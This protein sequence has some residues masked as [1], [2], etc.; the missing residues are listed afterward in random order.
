MWS[1]SSGYYDVC[2]LA[3]C[4]LMGVSVE[5]IEQTQGEAVSEATQAGQEVSAIDVGLSRDL[6]LFD[7]TMIGVG[8]MIGAGIFVLTGIAAGVA[9]P[10]LVLAFA[11]NGIVTS[12]T[13]MSYAELGSAFPQAGGGYVWV[14]E[15]LGGLQGFL[16]GWMSWFAAAVAGSLY[17]LAF[18][19]F[20]VEL[21]SMAGLPV[22]QH[23]VLGV[24]GHEIMR[25]LF[26]TF[27]VITFTFINFMGAS[28]TGSVGNAITLAKV[29]I[30]GLFTAFGVV[31][32]LHQ[33]A[34]HQRFSEGFMPNGI[35]GVFMAMGLTFIAFEGYEIIAQSGEEVIDPKRNVPRA[36]FWAI[37]ISV[38]IYVLVAFTTIGAIQVPAE[39]GN[40]PAYQYLGLEKETAIVRAAEQF[41]PFGVGGVFLL[42]SGLASTMSALNAVTYSSSRVSFAMGRDRNL[43]SFFGKIHDRR[44]TPFLAVII[45]GTLIAI[46]AWSLPIEALAAA[47]DIMFLLLFFQVNVSTMI[48]RRKMPELD[49]GFYI[50]WFPVVPIIGLFTQIGLI[51]FLFQ[52][53]PRAFFTAAGWVIGGALLYY[54]IFARQEARERPSEILLEEVLVS[55]DFSVL[56]PVA[57][58]EQA[59]IL[60][61]IGAIIAKD[62]Q[63]GVL[64]LHV[65]RVPPQL[66]LADGRYFLREG[67][68][69]L[70]TVIKQARE[71][72]V[73]V[74]TMIRLSRD[75]AEA[76]RT[77]A[78]ENASNLLVL[79]WPGYTNTAGRLFG[80]VMDPLIDNP[81]ID[82]AIVRYREQRPL[83]SIFVPISAG[84]NSRRAVKLAVSMASQAEGGPA[85][86]HVVTVIP[87][88]CPQNLRV[89]AQQAIAHALETSR[90]YPHITTELIEG[91]NVA[92]AIV[93]ASKGHDLIVMGSTEE[94]MFRNLLTGSIPARVAKNA[95]VTVIIVKRRSGMI[96]SVL[97]QTVLPPS[98]GVGAN[99]EAVPEAD[100]LVEHGEKRLKGD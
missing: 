67:R 76:V 32:L 17:A 69:F 5:R 15:A 50:P 99:G 58:Q 90:T 43:P 64:A 44:H 20:A 83:R 51:I 78:I 53:E 13:A 19:A 72:D 88:D 21:W 97:R 24:A 52:Y 11:L 85:R 56:V 45:S 35:S 95:E 47:A 34:W 79:G 54:T 98:T 8:A 59:R 41:F 84:P 65:A 29:T 73:P 14:R 9:G 63:G 55:T 87:Y 40:I 91:H 7:I 23:A 82:V 31:A 46:M 36:I 94:P 49:R 66:T 18:G 25:L 1:L 92:D 37:G 70:E 48:L 75:V 30:L 77:T 60:G 74:H 33:E 62:R 3:L 2:W 57:T 68:P 6:T 38:L 93:E 27:I 96:R 80:S 22:L 61:K 86:V 42:I 89:R 16:S 4:W 12:F 26:M 81:P 28:E 100:V 71:R 39:Y 10:A